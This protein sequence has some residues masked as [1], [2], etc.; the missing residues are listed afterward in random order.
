M[1][2]SQGQA[3]IIETDAIINPENVEIDIDNN[4]TEVK[5]G[6]I[7]DILKDNDSVVTLESKEEIS[8][9]NPIEIPIN[10]SGLARSSAGTTVETINIQAPSENAPS[11]GQIVIEGAGEDGKDLVVDF[12]EKNNDSNV[13]TLSTDGTTDTIK[14]DLGKQVAVS[15]VTIKI[16]GSKK[17]KNLAE[18][19]KVEFLNN[20]YKEAPKPNMNIP[21]INSFT[22]TTQVG[23]ESMTIGWE[24][25]TNVTGYE[26]EVTN[27]SNG[28]KSTYKTS[29]NSL[30]IEKVE[31][32]G[33]Y[34]I[35]IQSL[36]GDW[37]SGY[38]DEQEDYK[39]EVTGT[40]NLTN[41]ANDKVQ[42][43]TK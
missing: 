5:G 14:I 13:S 6:N 9:D 26:I 43:V 10:L 33:V 15:K 12:S 3:T 22:S 42:L 37:K 8:E 31:A 7:K 41:N 21:V 27:L 32:Y 40:T 16:T 39:A 17:N 2:N 24:H 23:Q 34:R 19:A 18:I 11:S 25:E 28:S 29:K 4:K 38:K 1:G 36:S 30:K 20:V 35:R